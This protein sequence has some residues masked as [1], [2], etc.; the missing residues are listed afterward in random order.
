[1]TT[2]ILMTAGTLLIH[3]QALAQGDGYGPMDGG[4]H[5]MHYG[6]GGFLMWILL[7]AGIILIVLL[8]TQLSK[9]A[10]N[11]QKPQDSALDILKKRYAQGE[12]NK[13]EFERM[14]QDLKN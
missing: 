13:E 10:S 3:A 1:M 8:V 2:I 7:I 11:R 12:I 6:Y 4:W 14:K 9:G 5:M